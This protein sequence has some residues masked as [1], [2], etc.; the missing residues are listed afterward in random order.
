MEQI[1]RRQQQSYSLCSWDAVEVLCQAQ[2]PQAGMI[3]VPAATKKIWPAVFV[4]FVCVLVCAC[5]CACWSISLGMELLSYLVPCC[6][7]DSNPFSSWGGRMS[8]S[9]HP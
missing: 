6:D 9:S 8:S 1:S 5:V 7:D 2:C 4:L 3:E